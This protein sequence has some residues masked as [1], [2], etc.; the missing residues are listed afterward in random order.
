MVVRLT[1]ELREAADSPIC[2]IAWCEIRELT[3]KKDSPSSGKSL[4]QAWLKLLVFHLVR[5]RG[6]EPPR[7]CGH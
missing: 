3:K 6:L 1:T 4:L 5:M 2:D 7:P